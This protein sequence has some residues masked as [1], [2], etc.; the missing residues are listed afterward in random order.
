MRL[1]YAKQKKLNEIDN[2]YAWS[3]LGGG[4]FFGLK[5]NQNSIHFSRPVIFDRT[6][7]AL[8]LNRR[9][10]SEKFSDYVYFVR[11]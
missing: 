1:K 10:E 11:Y 4:V 6:S 8:S 2:S 9:C 3:T 5:L 7:K